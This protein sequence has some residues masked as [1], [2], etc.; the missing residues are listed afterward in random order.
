MARSTIAIGARFARTGQPGK[1]YVVKEMRDVPGHQKHAR[2]VLEGGDE[3]LLIGV[4]A[5]VDGSFYRRA[6]E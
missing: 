2:L 4:S 1:V 5:L 3:M 6:P